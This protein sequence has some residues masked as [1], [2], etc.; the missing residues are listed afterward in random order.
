MKPIF[1]VLVCIAPLSVRATADE[2]SS[3][4]RFVNNDQL[5]GKLESL[6]MDRLLWKSPILETPTAFFLKSVLDLNLVPKHPLHEA[7]HEANLTLTNGDTI[8]GQLLAVS[9]EAVELDTWFAGHLKF[10]RVMVKA[11][12]I[13]ERPSYT[14][15]GPIALSEWT[16]SNDPPGWSFQ[17]A[18]LISNTAGSIAKDV[19]LADECRISFVAA[20][21]GSFG[22]KLVFFSDQLNAESPPNGYEISFQQRAI[23]ARSCK[24]SATLGPGVSAPAL[25]ENEKARIEVRASLKSGSIAVFIDGEIVGAWTD[26]DMAQNKVGRGIHFISINNSPVR[27]S[28]I[29]I[30]PWDGVL[31]KMPEVNRP[32]GFRQFEGMEEEPAPATAPEVSDSNR[33]ILRNGDSIAGEVI[34]IDGDIVKVK[35][36]FKDVK[37]P[38]AVLKSVALKPMDLER[39]KRENGDVRAWFPDGTSIVFRLEAIQET[40]MTGYS[41]NFGTAEFQS[42]AFNR[43]EFNIY[44]RKLE[45]LRVMN[46]W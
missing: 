23:F 25:Q 36:P 15:E 26:P 24:T 43:I 11:I 33:M 4:V 29:G 30:G 13:N 28:Q 8:N 5:S 16:Q 40:T 17:N 7:R 3:V 45:D 20:W 22:L 32:G 14:Y 9:D 38:V 31:E 35:T 6:S 46:K 12:Q 19:A 44:D 2:F 10:R 39:C 18:A 21:R 41:Q 27:I 1:L 42:A 34:G 37:I